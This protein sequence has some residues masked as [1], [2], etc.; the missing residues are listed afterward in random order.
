MASILKW[1]CNGGEECVLVTSVFDSHQ[2]GEGES[3][4]TDK[5]P[6]TLGLRV[7]EAQQSIETSAHSRFG[8]S[9]NMKSSVFVILPSSLQNGRPYGFN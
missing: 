2:R 9:V 3:Y 6:R 5:D 4:A 1:L 8:P 7:H